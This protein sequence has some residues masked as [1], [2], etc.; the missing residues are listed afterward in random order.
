LWWYA[1]DE[2]GDPKQEEIRHRAAQRIG[3]FLP[4]NVVRVAGSRIHEAGS[5]AGADVDVEA[6]KGASPP[7]P[8]RAEDDPED[9]ETDSAR[10]EGMSKLVGDDD[11]EQANSEPHHMERRPIEGE[12]GDDVGKG[13]SQECR[14]E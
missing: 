2:A 6:E 5:R 10:G 13:C 1:G 4:T 12:L 14:D 9:P 7:R 3:D 11:Q 8:A